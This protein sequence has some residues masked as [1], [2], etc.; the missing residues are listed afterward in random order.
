[1]PSQRSHVAKYVIIVPMFEAENPLAR[2]RLILV[3]IVLATIPCYCLGGIAL[4]FAPGPATATPTP[5]DTSI[6]TGTTSATATLT[7]TP[8]PTGTVSVTPT[9]D[10]EFD[11]DHHR[12]ALRPSDVDVHAFAD[13]HAGADRH[14]GSDRNADRHALLLF[15]RTRLRQP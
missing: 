13:I 6:A 5:T 3:A 7:E 4:I 10:H 2:R 8:S 9:D 12:Y 1:M 11:P 15:Q 14:T